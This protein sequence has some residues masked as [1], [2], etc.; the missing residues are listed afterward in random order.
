MKHPTI[1]RI[2]VHALALAVL[3]ACTST[4]PA[5]PAPSIDAVAAVTAIRAAG[6][7]AS[8]ELDV[9]PIRDPQVDDLRE[10]AA[11]FEKAGQY[12]QA[13]AALDQALQLNPDDPALLQE[14]AEAA[15]L[16]K[17]L[18]GAERF[19]RLGIERG[20]K[21]GPLCRRHWETIAQVRQARPIP[22][23]VP[24]DTVAD[25]RRERDACTVAAPARY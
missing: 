1:P 12:A 9:Q 7:A 13:V 4:P 24:G 11:A 10:D 22:L 23:E 3:A 6:G 8:T 18:A 19:A 20:S 14:R 15:L 25:A 17:D 5:P 2:A 16:V 21:V